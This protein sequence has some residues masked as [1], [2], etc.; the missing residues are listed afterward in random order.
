MSVHL[1]D[2]KCVC[3]EGC[4]C[5]RDCEV[6]VYVKCVVCMCMR[7]VCMCV[8]CMCVCER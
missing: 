5:V 6:C 1:P 7:S 3:E 4:E 2:I 8:R